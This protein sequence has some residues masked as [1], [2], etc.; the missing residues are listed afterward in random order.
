MLVWV[1][2]STK[3]MLNI[4]PACW[5]PLQKLTGGVSTTKQDHFSFKNTVTIQAPYKAYCP[6]E[7]C[8]YGCH[9]ILGASIKMRLPLETTADLSILL[10]GTLTE[11]QCF[12]EPPHLVLLWSLTVL[13]AKNPIWVSL[14]I[15]N[16]ISIG[17]VTESCWDPQMPSRAI[18]NAF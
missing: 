6:C 15:E 1:T 8:M 16:T 12:L 17:H 3:N 4:L 13:M 9:A 10:P 11:H 5:A 14:W 2:V 7:T 18:P